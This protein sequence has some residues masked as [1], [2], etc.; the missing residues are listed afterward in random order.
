MKFYR[1]QPIK[2]EQF[3]GSDKMA[4]KYELIDAGTMLGTHHSPELYLTGSGKVD[5]GDWIAT[6]VNGEHWPI[7]DDVFKKTYA[8]LPV[9][10]KA[11]ADYMKYCKNPINLFFHSALYEA[12]DELFAAS[13]DVEHWID[14][15]SDVFARAWLDGYVVE[16]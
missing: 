14:H 16:E 6:G 1:K 2:A 9:I 11:V 7:A 8:E 3:D 4:D 5:V 10:P 13:H 15:N 12:F